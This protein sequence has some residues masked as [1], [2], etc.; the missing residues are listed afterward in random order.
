M[1]ALAPP[2]AGICGHSQ[3]LIPLFAVA[4]IGSSLLEV[5]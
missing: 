3:V 4:Y 5:E 1:P 2:S